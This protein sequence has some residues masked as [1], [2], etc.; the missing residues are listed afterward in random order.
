VSS[1]ICSTYPNALCLNSE[2][3]SPSRNGRSCSYTPREDQRHF[4]RGVRRN[5]VKIDLSVRSRDIAVTKIGKS[6]NLAVSA[7]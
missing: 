7:E 3:A 6:G 5:G 1:D 4:V 2:I